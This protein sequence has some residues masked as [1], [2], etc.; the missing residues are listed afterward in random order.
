MPGRGPAKGSEQAKLIAQIGGNTRWAKET[1]RTAA[2]QCMRD[3]LRAS[4]QRAVLR[5]NPGLTDEA[6]IQRRVDALIKA[7]LA[8]ARLA[9]LKTRQAKAAARKQAEADALADAV[10]AAGGAEAEEGAA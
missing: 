2:T 10:I 8:R 6:E 1:N 3:G 9:S 4:Y 7:Q 5:D